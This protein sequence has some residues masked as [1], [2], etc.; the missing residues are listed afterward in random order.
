ML[1]DCGSFYSWPLNGDLPRKLEDGV[2]WESDM[3][4]FCFNR[5]PPGK[6]NGVFMDFSA[7]KIGLKELW[8]LKWHRSYD[9]DYPAPPWPEWMQ[10]F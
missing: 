4:R 8:R 2:P 6:I 7:R 3:G 5:H 10:D 1:L 9:V